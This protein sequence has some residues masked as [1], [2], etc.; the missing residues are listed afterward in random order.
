VTQLGSVDEILDF[1]IAG[2]EESAQF[3]TELATRMEKPSIRR[4]FE[5]FSREE[6]AH[7]ARLLAIKR[8]KVLSPAAE[9]VADLKIGDY[10]I[11]VK[12]APDMEY[13]DA[14]ILAMKR[15][16]ASFKLY[17][18]LAAATENERLRSALLALAQEEAKHK[19]RFE[20]EYDE[21]V[22]KEG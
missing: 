21:Y 15:E 10:L 1:A 16:K 7:K 20:I 2:E 6:L 19:L 13:Q 14:L 9:R 12:P 5:D 11:D 17:T 8:E 4:L 18:D 22:L 3:Y